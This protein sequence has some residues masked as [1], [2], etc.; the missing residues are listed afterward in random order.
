[1][2][3]IYF[4]PSK[5]SRQFTILER[6]F[7]LTTINDPRS[8]PVVWRE[9]KNLNT[10]NW[11]ICLETQNYID[12][13][14]PP[15]SGLS[16][17]EFIN[18]KAPKTFF[19]FENWTKVPKPLLGIYNI[20]QYRTYVVLHECGHALGLGHKRSSIGPAPIMLQQTKGLKNS[21]KNIWPLE[22][23]INTLLKIQLKKAKDL[24]G[25]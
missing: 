4:A 12:N 2:M 18:N 1:M 16:V 13:T 6:H 7:I 23:E 10:S 17:T 9:T 3:F 25:Y 15:I 5:S 22:S 11:S 8:W 14:F 19:S 24:I 20:H 21:N